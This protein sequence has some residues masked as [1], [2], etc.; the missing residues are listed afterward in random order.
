[1]P[2]FVEEVQSVADGNAAEFSRLL[3]ER[4]ES[5]GEALGLLEDWTEASRETR[6]ELT[7]KYDSAKNLAR[8]E[9]RDATDDTAP[10]DETVQTNDTDP[11]DPDDLSAEELLDH[12]AVGE[13]TK[14]R[15]REYSTKL[16]IYLDEE[17][18]YGE[19]RTEL[20]RAL[21]AELGLYK[22]LLPELERGETSVQDAQQQIA[23]FAR[24]E[25]LGPP[26]KTGADVLLESAVET[27]E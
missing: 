18:A 2:T 3:G 1:M 16:F 23:R 26:N 9:I 15:L 5:L 19:A 24:E 11:T 21:D 25:T 20:V 7:S 13:R 27:D 8:D 12:P 10:T 22:H 14:E 6:T 17:S 4:I